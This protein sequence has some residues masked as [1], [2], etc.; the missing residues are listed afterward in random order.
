MEQEQGLI[1]ILD[2]LG[3]AT[4][5]D[6]EITK[7]L[8]SR[9]RVIELLERNANAKEVRGDIEASRITTFTFNDTVLVVY[10]TVKPPRLIDFK[11]FGLLLRKF[12]VDS[13]AKGI[14]FRG[15]LSVGTF[16]VDDESNTVMGAAVTDAAAWYDSADWIGVHATPHATLVIQE[17]L[18]HGQGT[19]DHVLVDYAVPFKGQPSLTL[20]AINWPKIFV[21]PH[22]APAVGPKE[23]RAKCLWLLTK[24]RVPKG[25]EA[26]YF[27]SMAFFEHCVAHWRKAKKG[28]AG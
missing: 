24:H 27:N 21:V 9:G 18:E 11:H 7:F 8:E 10:R 26:K 6:P 15:S 3:A 17:L 22:L 25:T 5:T 28:R 4:Y 20:K 16:Y 2:A 1:A 19:L 13:L 12:C 14:L 23:P